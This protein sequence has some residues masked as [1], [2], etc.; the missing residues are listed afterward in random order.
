MSTPLQMGP[1]DHVD[2]QDGQP[3]VVDVGEDT[4]HIQDNGQDWTQ[5]PLE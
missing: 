2:G 3:P 1:E 4:A 5:T